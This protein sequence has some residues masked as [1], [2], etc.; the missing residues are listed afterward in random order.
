M[1]EVQDRTWSVERYDRP[2]TLEGALDLVDQHR[3]D[4]RIL[5]GGTDLLLE[6]QRKVRNVGFLVDLSAIDGLDDITLDGGVVSL[7]PLVTHRDV[8]ASDLVRAHGL[9]LAQACLEVGSA[10]LRNRATVVGNVVT[11]SPANDTISALLALDASLT[12]ASING[13]RTVALSDFYKGV[14]RTVMADNEIVTGVSFPAMTESDAGIFAKVGLRSAQA[15]SVVHGSILVSRNNG[16][17]SSARIALGSVAP[18]VVLVQAADLLIGNSL[19]EETIKQ[20]AA[21]CAGEVTPISDGRATAEYRTAMVEVAVAR[22]LRSLRDGTEA[23]QWPDRVTLLSNG[24]KAVPEPASVGQDDN[25]MITINGVPTSGSG[26]CNT[27]LLNWIREHATAANGAPL[28]GTKEGCAEGECGACTVHMDGQA[29]LACLV[30]A[31]AAHGSEVT[32]IEGLSSER[33]RV[34]Q[35]ALVDFGA[36]QCGFCTPGFVMSASSLLSEH[37]NLSTHEIREGL[38]GNI[39]RCTGYDSIVAA[40][41]ISDVGR[42]TDGG[43]S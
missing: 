12:L 22:M 4:V 20:C 16:I 21:A 32:T 6:M 3:S 37:E 13:Q 1:H 30:A 38:S 26:A 34:M 11:A 19:S 41:Q 23:A 39:C 29:V 10:Q 28:T 7:G 43:S 18:V 2:E 35:D 27:T 40:V 17:V 15:I 24:T 36:V 33:D 5:A 8:I 25:V 9:P 14:R 31:P 42:W